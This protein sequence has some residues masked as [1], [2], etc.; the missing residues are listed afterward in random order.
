MLVFPN[1]KINI[2]LNITEKRTDG[3]HNLETVFYPISLSDVLEFTENENETVFTNTGIQI[4]VPSDKNLVLQAYYLLKSEFYLPEL[5]IHLHKITPLGAGLGGGSSDASYMLKTLNDHFKLDL[6]EEKL[7]DYS[8]KLGSDCPFFIKNKP[9]FAEG[10][11]NI[12]T[13]IDLDL[14]SFYILLVKP[15]I[16]ISTKDAF[17][18]IKPHKPKD[19][20][21]E[22][23]KQPIKEWKN[24][25]VNDFEKNV[26]TLYPGL[27]EIKSILYNIGAVYAQMSGSGATVFGIFENKPKLPSEFQ[28]YFVFMEKNN[29]VNYL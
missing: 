13:E 24:I 6:S 21:T 2:G 12:F 15:D 3:F 10:T 22:L 4:D 1:T 14:S 17:S 8:Q 26:F 5:N 19:P 20:L 29:S 7:I 25:I 28:N 16:H 11:G 9:L 27:K 18:N 23:I